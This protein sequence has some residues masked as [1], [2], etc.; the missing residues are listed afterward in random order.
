MERNHEKKEHI[1][2]KVRERI[3]DELK[4]LEQQQ[5]KF[6]SQKI[7]NKVQGIKFKRILFKL[8][9]EGYGTKTK[10]GGL[11]HKGML[12]ME[13]RA[14]DLIVSILTGKSNE[15]TIPRPSFTREPKVER[16]NNFDGRVLG[17]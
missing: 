3:V 15:E 8:R 10:D 13:V 14:G 5:L 16:S 9:R 4:F 11:R 2:I 17:D 7:M 1:R 6:Q 12:V